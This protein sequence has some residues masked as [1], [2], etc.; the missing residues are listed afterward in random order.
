VT[1]AIVHSIL[2]AGACCGLWL[3]WHR[4][5]SGAEPRVQLIVG[6]GL[7]ARALAG[8]LLFWISFLGLPVARSM[9]FGGG[10]WFFG[11]DG[12]AYMAY[13]NGIA[14][15]GLGSLLVI[16]GPYPS[17]AFVQILTA[18]V[19][20]FGGV[21]AVGLLVNLLAYL[22]TCALLVRLQ[23]RTIGALL[24]ALAALAFG[25]A[26]LLWSLQPLKDTVFV[27]I[28]TML[29]VLLFRWQER[30]RLWLA[31]AMLVLF[32][33]LATLRWY[34]ALIV[35]ALLPLF[36][37]LAALR[38]P[39]RRAA[40]LLAGL[41]LFVVSSQAVRR[42]GATD[43]HPLMARFLDPQTAIEA[44]RRPQMTRALDSARRGFEHT[45]GNTTLQPGH[46]LATTTTHPAQPPPVTVSAPPQRR[47]PPPPA[48]AAQRIARLLSGS[49]AGLLPRMIGQPLGLF[50]VGGGRGL[51]LFADA[52]TLALDAVLV[53]AAVYCVRAR[54]RVTPLFVLVLLVL[55]AT[56]GPLFYT[57]S[58]FGTLLRLRGMI[59]FLAAVLPLTL[60]PESPASGPGYR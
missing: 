22:V 32:Y 18:F 50:E 2:A 14:G 59:Y 40:A 17:R 1:A 13:A 10:Y 58:N 21:E 30:P 38:M 16:E 5:F 37:L 55:L 12:A 33:A 26:V 54:R 28:L 44:V 52:D 15:R 31:A 43:I 56:G 8:Q 19:A 11:L 9:H 48:T 3:L 35:W 27:C 29:I 23:P 60:A 51:W 49:A 57:V 20:A 25:P 36:F 53:F 39:R 24:F 42:G 45:R 41:L 4:W 46:V 34:M 47:A 7:L 6:L